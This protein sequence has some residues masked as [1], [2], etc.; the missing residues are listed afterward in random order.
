MTTRDPDHP[1]DPRAVLLGLATATLW[2]AATAASSANLPTGWQRLLEVVTLAYRGP[3][4]HWLLVH[5]SANSS[6]N[7]SFDVP[8]RPADRARR[9]ERSWVERAALGCGYVTALVGTTGAVA[10]TVLAAAVLAMLLWADALPAA[11]LAV[12]LAVSWTVAVTGLA[13][14]SA[15]EGLTAVAAIVTA[16]YLS[17]S[18]QDGALAS[19]IDNLV[20]ELGPR[21]GPQYPV[22]ASL[23]GALSDPELRIRVFAP[24]SGW[25]DEIGRPVADPTA[26]AGQLTAVET[27][28]GGRVVLVHGSP[29]AAG[30]GFSRAAAAAAA[31]VLERVQVE[32]EVRTRADDVRRSTL[33]LL[34]V[35]DRER[36]ALARRLEAG[37]IARLERLGEAL[38]A[39]GGPNLAPVREELRAVVAELHRLAS[40]L[41]PVVV[42][43]GQLEAV[44]HRVATNSPLPVALSVTGELARLP[45]ERAALAYFLV[46]ECLTNT[47][48]HAR[49][50]SARCLVES[51]ADTGVLVVEV[52]DD[53]CGGA[54]VAAGRGLRGLADRV[55]A[56][57]GTLEVNSPVG[58]PTSVR[59][60]VPLMTEGPTAH[61]TLRQG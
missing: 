44:L 32:T 21:D 49:A 4:L 58:G 39:R 57:G 46:S 14:N 41:N 43:E 8:G 19:A 24:G 18:A 2:F 60:A 10:G 38:A 29:G 5:A 15:A 17:R 13:P 25:R 50:S 34:G 55:G 51:R 30:T 1:V 53:G 22:S 36:T 16:A 37:P 52:W 31:L 9:R 45:E 28:A 35:D 11:L 7:A 33:R 54:S 12:L 42:T 20:L 56:A 26:I 23:A 6:P 59:A 47:I 61:E 27:P 3:L 48:R 40:G